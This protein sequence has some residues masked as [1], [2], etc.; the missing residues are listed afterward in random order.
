MPGREAPSE[1]HGTASWARAT[2][3]AEPTG[4]ACQGPLRGRAQHSSGQLMHPGCGGPTGLWEVGLSC[5]HQKATGLIVR[6]EELGHSHGEDS[7]EGHH[8]EDDTDCP[9]SIA[10][11]PPLGG[12]LG[13]N[14]AGQVEHVAQRPADVGVPHLRD[15]WVVRAAASRPEPHTSNPGGGTCFWNSMLG[16]VSSLKP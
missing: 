5:Q 13:G 10:L 8:H 11:C 2:L 3:R 9:D 1:D 4:Q 7:H 12:Q 16:Q 6:P 15:T 14:H